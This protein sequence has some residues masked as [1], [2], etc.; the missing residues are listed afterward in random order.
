[1][2]YVS[3]E[4]SVFLF[5]STFLGAVSGAYLR[6]GNTRLDDSLPSVTMTVGKTE[7]VFCMHFTE[8]APAGIMWYDP[9]DR[10]VSGSSGDAVY[11]FIADGGRVATLYFKSYQQRQRG[12]YECRVDSREKIVRLPVCI[13]EWFELHLQRL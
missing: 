8:P 4:P 6:Y 10:L 11:Q 2:R 7:S 3:L 12:T 13:G 9:Q 1:M 5:P